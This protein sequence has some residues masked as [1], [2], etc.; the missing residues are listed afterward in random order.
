[1]T[2]PITPQSL[3]PLEFDLRAVDEQPPLSVLLIDDDRMTLD[4]LEA[5]LARAGFLVGRHDTP[6]G[7]AHVV[8]TARPDV[9]LMDVEMGEATGRTVL[10]HLRRGLDTHGPAGDTEF[11]LYSGT[12]AS[13]LDGLCKQVN[14][15]GSIEKSGDFQLFL[16]K[17]TLLLHRSPRLATRLQAAFR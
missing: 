11:I 3:H 17:F 10:T 8:N 14:A 1:M 7:S 16:A 9:V 12:R 2:F 4:V 15:L 5:V 13:E 6:F